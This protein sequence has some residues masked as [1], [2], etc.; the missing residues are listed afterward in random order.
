MSRLFASDSDSESASSESEDEG[1]HLK[2]SRNMERIQKAIA[3]KEDKLER[4]WMEQWGAWD[5]V[6]FGKE[7]AELLTGA[8]PPTSPR[9]STPRAPVS[10]R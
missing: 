5:I 6:L 1:Y 2:A 7:D 4:K 9:G 3:K 8:R 10:A